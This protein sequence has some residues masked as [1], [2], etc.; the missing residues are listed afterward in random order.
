MNISELPEQYKI[1]TVVLY[2]KRTFRLTGLELAS[3]LESTAPFIQ[4]NNGEGFSKAN[5]ASWIVDMDETRANVQ[6][7]LEEIRNAIVKA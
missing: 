7:H 3:A 6:N 5:L 1:Y 2:D 4:L